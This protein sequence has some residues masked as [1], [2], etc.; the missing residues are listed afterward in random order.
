MHS[1]INKQ[2][3][4][5]TLTFIDLS[6]SHVKI[7]EII[8][9]SISQVQTESTRRR[10]SFICAQFRDS[11]KQRRNRT[12]FTTF[13]LH[14]LEQA[15]EKCH[16]P[17]VYAREVRLILHSS[18]F[19][20][21]ENFLKFFFQL[22]AQKVKLPEVR[23]QVWFQNRRAKWRRQDKAESSAIADLPP[24]RQTTSSGL[25]SWTWMTANPD[26]FSGFMHPFASQSNNFQPADMTVKAAPPPP[27]FC[28]GY[29][30]TNPYTTTTPFTDIDLHSSNAQQVMTNTHSIDKIPYE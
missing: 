26:E 29:L 23:V 11:K 17:D 8:S 4:R 2:T 21:M 20:L 15:F 12:T 3:N 10:E 25:H 27:P 1:Q 18:Y 28:F 30:P 13:Q 9:H 14:E 6:D 7:P 19:K 22:L 24:V 5:F 16:Y